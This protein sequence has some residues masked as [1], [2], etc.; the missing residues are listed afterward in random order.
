MGGVLWPESGGHGIYRDSEHGRDFRR[1]LVDGGLT[2]EDIGTI[3][4]WFH[5]MLKH[6]EREK[7]A[8]GV[9]IIAEEYSEAGCLSPSAARSGHSS[10]PGQGLAREEGSQSCMQP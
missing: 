10:G 2:A 3:P 6:L 1:R 5:R 8:D 7:T 9:L 4:E